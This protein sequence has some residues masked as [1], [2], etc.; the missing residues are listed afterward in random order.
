MNETIFD[1][2]IYCID[3]GVKTICWIC[4]SPLLIISIPFCPLIYYHLKDVEMEKKECSEQMAKYYEYRTK[5]TQEEKQQEQDKLIE[6]IR[7]E[8]I[9]NNKI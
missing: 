9:S 5:Q 4:I 2:L 7:S 8:I 3:F 6:I 1:K